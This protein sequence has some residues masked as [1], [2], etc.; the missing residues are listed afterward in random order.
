MNAETEDWLK[1]DDSREYFELLR[2][3]TVGAD[4]LHLRD[5]VAAAMWLKKWL[6]AIGAEAELVVPGARSA[7]AEGEGRSVG[8]S[9]SVPVVV[10]ERKGAEGAP[11]VLV[12]GHYDVQPV[13]PVSEWKTPPFEPTVEGDRVYCRGAQDDK[14]Q[15]FAFLCGIREYLATAPSNLNLKLSDRFV[16]DATYLRLKNIELSYAIPCKG[17]VL[18]KAKVYVSGQNLVTFTSYPLWNPDVNAKGGGSSLTQ[19]VDASC[20][21]IARTATLG[22]RLTF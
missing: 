7:K 9:S 13:D 20:Y 8:S 1:S 21:P 10:A 14:G 22:C 19:G 5:C 18:Q 11:T 4:P 12:Y 15:F 2:M 16:Y 6:E 17:K 3:P